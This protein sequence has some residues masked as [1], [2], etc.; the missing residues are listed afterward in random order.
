MDIESSA[1]YM[2]VWQALEAVHGEADVT[3]VIDSWKGQVA[4]VSHWERFPA[5]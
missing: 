3:D 2:C 1:N 5:K 4:T